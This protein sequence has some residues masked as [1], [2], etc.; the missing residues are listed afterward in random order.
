[1]DN[2]K[3]KLKSNISRIGS[4]VVHQKKSEIKCLLVSLN[5]NLIKNTWIITL[6]FLDP[7]YFK[8]LKIGS[9]EY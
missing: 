7:H 4:Y 8:E 3:K 9:K 6:V 5:Q 1:M 2:P